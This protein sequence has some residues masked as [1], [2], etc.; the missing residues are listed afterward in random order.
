MGEVGL[1]RQTDRVELI[2]GELFAM[3]CSIYPTTLLELT[4]LERQNSTLEY[5]GFSG[6]IGGCLQVPD[7]QSRILSPR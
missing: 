3:L 4:V 1:L 7:P 5:A 6:D 2:E